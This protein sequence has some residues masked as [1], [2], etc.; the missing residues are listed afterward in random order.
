MPESL[1]PGHAASVSP[2]EP[3]AYWGKRKLWDTRANNH[4][5]MFD[6]DG[7]IWLAATVR[8]QD[9]PA[10]C[11]KGSEN[12][13]A[14]IFPLEKSQRQIAVM[15]PKTQ[16]YQ[17]VDTCFGTHHPQ[18]GFDK[19]NTL[20]PSGTGQVAG[21]VN[22]KVFLETGDS[23]KAQGWAPFVLD[24]N[25]N[26][27][28]DE[29]VEPNQPADAAKDK[30]IVPGSGP[31]AVMPHPTDGS[32]WYTVGVFGGP[33]G[34]LRYDPKTKLSEVYNALPLH[35]HSASA[36]ATSTARACC[37][38][39]RSSGHLES[40]SIRA[41]CA[42]LRST[43]RRRPAITAPRAGRSTSIRVRASRASAPTAPSRAITPGSTSITS[44]GSATTCRSRPPTSATVSSRW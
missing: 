21:W 1:G 22:S 31:Y 43:A 36:V 32:I 10:F 41:S 44:W 7:R 29:F 35:R 40:A 13:Y 33:P 28:L 16:K 37:G 5:S 17:F 23:E 19:D 27:K 2:L 11:K 4:N 24:I 14:K 25:G 38:A 42:R 20:W 9:N 15:D 30:R 12:Q 8:G 34:F 3:S 39:R 26:G 6:Q 18:L